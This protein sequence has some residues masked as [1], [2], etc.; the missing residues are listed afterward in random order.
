MKEELKAIFKSGLFI[1][2][3]VYLFI[4]I[5]AAVAVGI[6]KYSKHP[7]LCQAIFVVFAAAFF[8]TIKTL[9]K[10]YRKFFKENPALTK[11][12]REKIAA[13][14]AKID[15]VIRRV[16]HLKPRS[17]YFGGKDE[18]KAGFSLFKKDEAEQ[19][20]TVK[21]VIK[22]KSLEENRAKIRF[23]FAKAVNDGIAS[24]YKYKYSHTARRLKADLAKTDRAKLLFDLYED[25]R[26]TDHLPEIE[27]E[28]IEYLLTPD[29]VETEQKKKRRK[30]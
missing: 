30:N 10:I 25:V 28:T 15:E 9:I 1:T 24:G 8:L 6:I 13:F 20:R 21:H 17:A 27:D 18:K 26:Y 5:A 23:M 12:I 22:W 14:F 2:F 4:S 11:A 16:L 7:Y 29:P 3:C 19:K